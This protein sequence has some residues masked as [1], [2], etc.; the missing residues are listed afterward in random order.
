MGAPY[1]LQAGALEGECLVTVLGLGL[2][3]LAL[4]VMDYHALVR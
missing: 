2:E 1:V 4:R 3:D